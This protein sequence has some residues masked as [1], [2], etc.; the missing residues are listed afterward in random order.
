MQNITGWFSKCALFGAIA[1]LQFAAATRAFAGPGAVDP[2]FNVVVNNTVYSVLT[3]P[4]GKILIGGAFTSVGGTTRY[5]LARLYPDGTLD[6]YS[7]PNNSGGTI[8]AMLRQPDGKLLIGG[9][10]SIFGTPSAHN[11]LARLN[12]DGSLDGTFTNSYPNGPNGPI[13]SLG[14]QSDGKVLV[15]G[16]FN[17]I[18]G[19]NRYYIARLNPD[20]TID[21]SFNPGTINGSSVNAIAVQGDG[22]I[23]IGGSFT[24]FSSFSLTRNNIARL[25]TNGTPDVSYGSSASGTVQA[26][27][28]QNNGKSMWAGNFGNLDIANRIDIGRLNSDGTVDNGFTSS[29]GPNGQVYAVTE[30]AN[31]NVYVGGTFTKFNNL[32]HVGVARLFSD[33]TLDASFNNSTNQ[34]AP[35]IRCLALQSDGK[36]LAGGAFTQFN[37]ILRTN[38]VR[39]Y[40]DTYPAEIVN[41]PKS[42]NAA[43]GSSVTFSVDV[44]NPTPVNYQWIKNG[45]SIPGATYAQYSLFNVQFAD[46][47]NYSVYVNSALGGTTSSN[48][49]LQVGIPPSITQQPTNLTVNQGQSATFTAAASG[50]SLVYYW[51]INGTKTLV[52]GATNTTLTLNNVVPS[53]AA[54]YYFVA[55]NVF[56]SATSAP[57][58]LSIL[59]P[60]TI[61]TNPADQVVPVGSTAYFS[62]IA[63]GNPLNYQWLKDGTPIPGANADIYSRTNLTLADAAGY[64]VIVSN[65]FGG[66]TSSVAKL[67]VGYPPVITLQPRNQT[68]D[69]GGMVAFNSAA[70]GTGPITWQ[71][72]Y[73]GI[74]LTNQNNTNLV[75]TNLQIANIGFYSVSANNAFGGTVSSNA[76]LNLNG[77]P[78]NLYFG[79][80]AYYPFSGNANDVTFNARN[81]VVSG[82]VSGAV[83]TTD[84]FGNTNSAYDFSGAQTI[85]LPGVPLT[86][87]DNWTMSA[88]LTADSLAQSGIAVCLGATSFL[89]D[90]GMEFGI[91]DGNF[92]NGQK[93]FGSLNGTA[94]NSGFS[95]TATN[96]WHHVVLLR[97]TG[98][99]WF[100]VDGSQT[101]TPNTTA[102]AAPTLFTLGSASNT[103]YYQGK[104]DEVRIYNKALSSSDVQQLY[105]F[106][107]A[108]P[109]IVQQPQ[110]QQRIIGSTANFTV[111]AVGVPVL[112]YQ[113]Y[114]SN[115]PLT[116]ATNPSLALSS[117]QLT[118]SGPYWVIVTNIFGAAASSVATLIVGNPPQSLQ[119]V[120]VPSNHTFSLQMP[121]TPGFNYVLQTTTNFSPPVIWQNIA[122][123]PADTNGNWSFIDTNLT[124]SPARFYRVSSP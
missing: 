86:Q 32:S 117:V 100:Y 80:V 1:S 18:G 7:L 26:V 12:V 34:T 90:N 17:A 105:N 31:G 45:V 50:T 121:G 64:S 87:T 58:A 51:T 98:I 92:G 48:A 22:N 5:A 19:T 30:D 40:G 107:S 66:M 118:D 4:D 111:Q 23:L 120:L 16:Q 15:G 44:S 42:L 29:S 10:F 61:L 109:Y 99:T 94:V 85:D 25:L 20:G 53:Q 84:R 41:Q 104:L 8:Y 28:L 35:Q 123:N 55:T 74:V 116:G 124:T 49:V 122:T 2:T 78:S 43:V 6:A 76:A 68:A 101:G 71:W 24:S 60:I 70:S 106:E 95:F 110:S 113:W 108:Q 96:Q 67:S 81:G 97:D 59:F 21:N 33:G 63:S 91:S 103:H 14:L 102:P 119:Y 37:G 13:Y 115:A 47:G 38:L 93:L 69:P 79:L 62:V 9:N 52:A 39:L 11:N 82:V 89:A 77:Y 72:Q 114:H 112:N 65:Q 75:L 57:A 83:L 56:G 54:N 73:N 3:Q 36:V 46:A 27:Y 88:W